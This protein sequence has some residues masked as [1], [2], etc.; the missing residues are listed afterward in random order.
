ML[1]DKKEGT[2][3]KGN[4]IK[5]AHLGFQLSK[6]LDEIAIRK[7]DQEGLNATL[8]RAMKLF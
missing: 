3:F 4:V 6:T 5:R 1:S 2:F 7:S 8:W